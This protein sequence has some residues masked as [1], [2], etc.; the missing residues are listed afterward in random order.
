MKRDIFVDFMSTWINISRQKKFCK[1][2]LLSNKSNHYFTF[3][4][5][6]IQIYNIQQS[7]LKKCPAFQQINFR[8][9]LLSKK[10]KSKLE[11][12][13]LPQYTLLDIVDF[14]DRGILF[15]QVK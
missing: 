4:N 1:N 2:T 11:S 7:I 12:R 5:I 15:D 8:D 14:E 6:G 10:N 3:S 13:T 9:A